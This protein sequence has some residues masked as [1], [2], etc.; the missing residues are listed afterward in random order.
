VPPEHPPDDDDDD[1]G[2]SGSVAG[3]QLWPDP[4]DLELAASRPG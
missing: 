3:E 2:G 1:G 4:L